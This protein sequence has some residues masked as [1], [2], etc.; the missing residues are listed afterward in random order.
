[1]KKRIAFLV[2]LVLVAS[3]TM[4]GCGGA[5]TTP[6]SSSG[7][8]KE[9]IK[10]APAS[11]SVSTT[12]GAK[13]SDDQAPLTLKYASGSPP[14]GI[15]SEM[16]K[17]FGDELEKRTSGKVKTEYFWSGSL[18]GT[19]DLA[20]AIGRGIADWGQISGM[21]TTTEH[22]HWS[23]I[24]QPGTT[25][26][27]WVSQWAAWELLHT[28]PEILAEFD[29]LNVVPTY[30]YGP[31]PVF[32]VFNREGTTLEAMKG[33]RFRTYGAAFPK[34][35]QAL[36]MVPVPMD[37]VEV[38]DALDKKVIDGA[39]GTIIL[40]HSQ[41]WYEVAKYWVEP[42]MNQ[43]LSDIA[44]FFNKDTWNKKLTQKTR[45]IIDRLVLDYNN[46]FTRRIVE[47][48]QKMRGDAVAAGVKMLKW[49]PEAEA[50]YDKATKDVAQ[51][52]I[53]D[54]EKKTPGVGK[55]YQRALELLAKYQKELDEKGYPWKR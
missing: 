18:V 13:S 23:V 9:G 52:I 8:T 41:K 4:I 46:E 3:T 55:V 14:T 21:F 42:R 22:P 1:M 26:D 19:P 38:Y 16:A 45:D 11:T 48:D 44:T 32:W 25:R 29:K 36:G 28:Q 17:W 15:A 43:D 51:A 53:A 20:R 12:E 31:G 35:A 30:T 2:A 39:M 6:A 40:A 10:S 34:I 50:A 27:V 24:N 37:G 5:S 33:V 7:T 49:S 47:Q 54:G